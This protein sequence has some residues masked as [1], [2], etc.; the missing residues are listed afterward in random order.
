[1]SQCRLPTAEE[2]ANYSNA[3]KAREQTIPTLNDYLQKLLTLDVALIGGGFVV[4]KGDVLSYWW[5]VAVLVILIVSLVATLVGLLPT[6]GRIKP[7]AVGGVE[8]YQSWETGIIEMK[9]RALR[10]GA[11]LIVLAFAV[12]VGG[13]V[14]KGPPKPEDPKPL[15]VVLQPAEP[16]T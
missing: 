1:M 8:A 7:H 11:S 6:R 12:G 2:A 10:L 14:A 13:L 9:N 4:A 3:L 15:T 5:G 16:K